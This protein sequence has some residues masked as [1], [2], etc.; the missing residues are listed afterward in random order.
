MFFD[1]TKNGA[2]RW[3]NLSA[4][5]NLLNNKRYYYE[6]KEIKAGGCNIDPIS[7]VN[8]SR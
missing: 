4:C 3:C 1:R 2:M 6:K 8:F 5:G 7:L